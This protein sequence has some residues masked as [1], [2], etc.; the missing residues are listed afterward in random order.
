V[1]MRSSHLWRVVLVVA[2]AAALAV[3]AAG[4]LRA[5]PPRIVILMVGDGMGPEQM[6]AASLFAAGKEGALYLE[7]L[8][9]KAEVVTCP[10]YA[11]PP[12]GVQWPVAEKAPAETKPSAGAK[13]PAD[14]KASTAAKE[15]AETKSGVAAKGSAEAKSGASAKDP[16]TSA[17]AKWAKSK[18]TDSAAA[19]TAMAAGQKVYNGVLSVALPGDG[20]PLGT[21]L[22]QAA[23][24]GKGTGLVTTSY[25]TDA[26]PAAFAS[27]ARLRS[28]QKEIAAGMLRTRPNVLLGGGPKPA[29]PPSVKGA[30]AQAATDKEV[31]IEVKPAVST[32][33]VP[34][35]TADEGKAAGFQVVTDRAGLDAVQAAAGGHVLGLFGLGP[36]CYEQL[37]LAKKKDDYDRLPHLSEMAASALRLL[38]A[39]PKGF[40]LMIEGGCIDKAC[41]VN[42]LAEA[43]QETIEFDKTVRL[44]AEWAAK[45]TDTLLLVT[46]DHET[47]GL[48]VIAANGQGQ[49]PDV[50]WAGKVH[51]GANVRLFAQ[52]PGSDAVKGTLDNTDIFRILTG[53]FTSPTVYR[54]PVSATPTP[55]LVPEKETEKETEKDD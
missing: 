28:L 16:L 32:P 4:T 9:Q 24:Q 6:K 17:K 40:F 31:L 14:T 33:K 49:L 2:M 36:M 20:L 37:Y 39:E 19:A 13:A 7:S 18:I 35:M 10:A 1:F 23:A 25:L 11:V 52:G 55:V 54:P 30:G 51:T 27:H 46:A 12:P 47:G 53:A 34:I 45:R 29:S 8:P 38:S 5:E 42:K 44:V 15:S 3:V 22:E 21:V 26:T 50:K 41:H 48:K 43:V